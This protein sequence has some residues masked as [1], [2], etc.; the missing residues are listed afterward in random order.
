MVVLAKLDYG[1]EKGIKPYTNSD[2]EDG[3][4][5]DWK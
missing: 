5:I 1:H 4:L 2:F 3:Y